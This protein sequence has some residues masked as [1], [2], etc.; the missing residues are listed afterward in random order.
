MK[1]LFIGLC[2]TLAFTSCQKEELEITEPDLLYRQYFYRSAT[3]D[4]MRR[5][6][7]DVVASVKGMLNI[8]DN[9]IIMK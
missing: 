6:L 3:S 5:D 1:H 8:K 4:T 7:N 2:L 9:E